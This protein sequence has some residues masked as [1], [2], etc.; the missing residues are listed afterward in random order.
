M[1][2]RLREAIPARTREYISGH[3]RPRL[4]GVTPA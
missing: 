3:V 2:T 1:M 4:R